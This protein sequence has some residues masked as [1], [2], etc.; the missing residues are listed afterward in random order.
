MTCKVY[1]RL[2]YGFVFLLVA[3][4]IYMQMYFSLILGGI[5]YLLL[6][7]V[8]ISKMKAQDFNAWATKRMVI[9]TGISCL[10][11]GLVFL[12]IGIES[13]FRHGPFTLLEKTIGFHDFVEGFKI[14]FGLD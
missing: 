8:A 6:S 7:T 5:A 10:L 9:G 2:I 13:S 4:A 14:L 12:F 3:A 11:A 1:N